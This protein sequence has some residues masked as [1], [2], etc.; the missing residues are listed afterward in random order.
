MQDS[1]TE[2]EIG[3]FTQGSISQNI[4]RLSFPIIVSQIVNVCY[5][6]VDRMYIGRIADIGTAALSSIGITLPL[7]TIISAFASLCGTGGLPLCAI[8]RGSGDDKKA[9]AIVEVSFTLLLLFAAVLTVSLYL[10]GSW[11]LT[12]IGADEETLPY[13]LEYFNIYLIGTVFVLISLGM[14]PF[15]NVQGFSKVGMGTTLIGAALNMILDPIFIFALGLGIRGAAIA[16][17]ISQF[18]GALWVVRFLTG[19]RASLRLQRLRLEQDLVLSILRLGITGFIF[20]ITNSATQ[21]VVNATLHV[22]GGSLGTLYIGAMSVINSLREVASQP[23]S[24]ITSGAQSVM[25]YN[26][27]AKQYGRV[28]ESIRFMLISTLSYNFVAWA[29]IMIFPSYL[30]WLFTPDQELINICIPYMRIYFAVFFMMSLQMTGQNT[31]VGLNKPKLAV[32][33]SLLR[34]VILVVPLTILLPRTGLGMMGVFYAE[35][36][37]QL[38][39]ASACFLTMVFTIW[40]KLKRLDASAKTEQGAKALV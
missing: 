21:A 23:I 14:N 6:L 40:R 19:P 24:G 8:T 26:Y 34:K 33:Y 17:V 29:I 28:S 38:I 25:G 2:K 18:F 11:A 9:Q 27:G 35:T 12:L 37:S 4:M 15:I 10:A 5:N 36:F 3:N 30:T 22:Y 1:C 20:K 31:Y 16:T 39:G 7:I 32:F 13:A